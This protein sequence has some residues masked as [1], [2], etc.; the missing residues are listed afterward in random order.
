MNL[1]DLLQ[2]AGARGSVDELA[3]SVGIP[4]S[5]VQD[6]IGALSPALVG[7]L[8][9]QARSSG[10]LEALGKALATGNHQRY[11]EQPD[12]M[13]SAATRDDGNKILGHLLGSKDVSRKVAA[14]AAEQ[15]GLEAGLIKKALP[16]VAGLAMGALSKKSAA[17]GRAPS[18]EGLGGLLGALVGGGDGDGP[19]VGDLLGLAKKLF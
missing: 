2:Q 5:K 18:A 10:G 4:A 13:A 19:G 15:T 11:V 7:S 6:L 8:A 12:L 14:R 16:L 9:K 17:G 1:M 3:G